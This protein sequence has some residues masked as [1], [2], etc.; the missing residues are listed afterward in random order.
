MAVLGSQ[1]FQIFKKG[2]G[3]RGKKRRLKKISEKRKK[4]KSPEK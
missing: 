1:K 3:A 4:K 2:R